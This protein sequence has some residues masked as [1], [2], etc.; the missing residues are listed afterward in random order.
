MMD[1]TRMLYKIGIIPVIKMDCM[2]HA[3]PLAK[4][5]KNG[6]LPAA[7]ITFRS[8]AAADSIRAITKEV[9]ELFV[10]AG[11]VLTVKNAELAVEAGAKAIISPGTNLSVVRWCIE[12]KIPVFPGCAT[13]TEVE[14]CM[15][16]GLSV[17]KLFPAE[18]VGGTAMLKAL[19]G[20]YSGMKFMPTGGVKPGNVKEYLSQKNVLAC[21]GTWMVPEDLLTDGKFD[22]IEA[23]TKE[24]AKLRDEIR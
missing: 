24:A 22:E 3:V 11:T 16:E 4:A 6:G 12:N 5:L 19:S 21:G 7:E 10:C 13:P 8:D 20:P 9:P 1:M 18:V 15:R 14:A 23:L 2:E 17:V